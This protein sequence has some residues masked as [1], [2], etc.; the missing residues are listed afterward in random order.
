LNQKPHPH[1]RATPPGPSARVSP[2]R[3]V[4][5][6]RNIAHWRIN[7][8]PAT[9]LIWTASEWEVLAERPP[10]AQYYP[11]GIWCALRMDPS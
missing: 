3:P 2:F 10:D 11:C 6:E 5:H 4:D 8:Y 9:I 7:G 1:R